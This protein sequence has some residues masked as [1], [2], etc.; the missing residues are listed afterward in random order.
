M[1][2]DDFTDQHQ[3][4]S[5]QVASDELEIPLEIDGMIISFESRTPTQ[6]EL[7]NCHRIALTDNILWE[8]T[9]ISLSGQT[10]A[11]RVNVNSNPDELQVGGWRGQLLRIILTME[12]RAPVCKEHLR[13]NNTTWHQAGN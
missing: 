3:E 5:I 13:S 2:C 10:N 7:E 1:L 4:L 12:H 11:N 6:E 8:P 9:N